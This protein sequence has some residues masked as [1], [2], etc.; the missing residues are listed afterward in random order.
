MQSNI[1]TL[2][3]VAID[4]ACNIQ[5]K[6]AADSTLAEITALYSTCRKAIVLHHFLTTGIFHTNVMKP[7]IIF[8]DNE[9]AIGLLKSNKLT[10]R[11]RHED[12]PIAFCYENYLLGYYKFH[13]ISTKLNAADTSTKPSTGPIMQRHWKFLHSLRFYPSLSTPRGL[14]LRTVPSNHT[15]LDSGK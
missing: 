10:Y 14:Y 11:S 12:V 3:G 15:I 13:H 1:T 6:V 4:W 8:A 9:A 7:I 5:S 2:N